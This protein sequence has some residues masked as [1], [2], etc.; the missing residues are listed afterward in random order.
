[1]LALL[2]TAPP[3]LALLALQ[4]ERRVGGGA[5]QRGGR[6]ATPGED[7]LC[8]RC[9]LTI[10]LRARVS[11][12]RARVRVRGLWL[13]W[14]SGKPEAA[15]AATPASKRS[16][17]LAAVE[18]KNSE[19]F[20]ACL[21]PKVCAAALHALRF[22]LASLAPRSSPSPARRAGPPHGLAESDADA[23]VP[24]LQDDAASVVDVGEFFETLSRKDRAVLWKHLDN[25]LGK[26]AAAPAA[27][28]PLL[29][30]RGTA[31]QRIAGT[32]PRP[33]WRPLLRITARWQRAR[34]R[35]WYPCARSTI[36]R[37]CLGP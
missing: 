6:S 12:A 36:V 1:M 16:V 3:P 20:L 33:A 32:A 11:F 26:P 10:L 34:A 22:E 25:F 7:V 23:T 9:E 27:P 35:V 19:S 28:P 15:A 31:R 2:E 37:T 17:L 21:E 13:A 8:A 29:T 18:Q 24:P 5:G 30:A 4:G 14:L